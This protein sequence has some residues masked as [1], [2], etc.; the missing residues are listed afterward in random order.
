[1]ENE[2]LWECSEGICELWFDSDIIFNNSEDI[3]LL[4]LKTTTS[5]IFC[6]KCCSSLPEVLARE[7]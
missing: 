7:C 3:F 1:M 2:L 6:T 4:T 5:L